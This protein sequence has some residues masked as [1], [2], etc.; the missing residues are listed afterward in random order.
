MQ[1]DLTPNLTPS[2]DNDNAFKSEIVLRKSNRSLSRSLPDLVLTTRAKNNRHSSDL[3]NNK[4]YLDQPLDEE[5]KQ[6]Q[7]KFEEE[8]KIKFNLNNGEL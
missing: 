4:N 8:T 3:C 2:Q 1:P 5:I 6:K 7:I